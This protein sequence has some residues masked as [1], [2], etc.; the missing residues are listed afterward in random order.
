[1]TKILSLPTT[2]PQPLIVAVILRN[3]DGTIS[4]APQCDVTPKNLAGML[5]DLASA[6][7]KQIDE[8]RIVQAAALPPAPL[9][10]GI[11]H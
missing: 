2:A 1:M 4:I 11:A 9:P 3:P 5:A 6:V 8:S 7:I 10:N